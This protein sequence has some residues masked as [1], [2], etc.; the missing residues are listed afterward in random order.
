MEEHYIANFKSHLYLKDC[1]FP[2]ARPGEPPARG[3][4]TQHSLPGDKPSRTGRA[5]K[6]ADSARRGFDGPPV[7]LSRSSQLNLE[8][9]LDICS[10]PG[11]CRICRRCQEEARLGRSKQPWLSR[12]RR[13]WRSLVLLA[14]LL[15]LLLLLLRRL[16]VAAGSTEWLADLLPPLPLLLLQPCLPNIGLPRTSLRR[17]SSTPNPREQL[18]PRKPR[19]H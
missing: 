14:R 5:A 18:R 17:C 2:A 16:R 9:A 6:G 10:P 19:P 3:A 11:R 1:L 8:G 4:R 7:Q 12:R 13:R 15:L